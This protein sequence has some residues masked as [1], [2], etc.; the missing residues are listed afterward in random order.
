M[1]LKIKDSPAHATMETQDKII[2]II[3]VS[4][5][6]HNECFEYAKQKYKGSDQRFGIV[7][8]RDANNGPWDKKYSSIFITKNDNNEKEPNITDP[9]SRLSHFGYQNLIN[10]CYKAKNLSELKNE[11][12]DMIGL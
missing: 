3:I 1:P 9:D 2:D 12:V 4:G 6:N 10:S 8:T 7:I 5:K 11:F